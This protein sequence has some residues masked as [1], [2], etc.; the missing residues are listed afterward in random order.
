MKLSFS[1]R[2]SLILGIG[3]LLLVLFFVFAQ[4]YYLT[5]LI[6]D[7]TREQ[8]TLNL[9]QKQ[10][11]IT[12]QKN[13][14]NTNTT[15]NDT[16]ELQQMI[17]VKP[18][19]DQFIL[20]LEKAETLSNSQIK[21]MSFTKDADANGG[22]NQANQQNANGQANTAANQNGI[23]QNTAPQNNANQNNANQN[24][25][26]QGS[27]N[28]ANKPASAAP[29]GL[30]KLTVNLSIESPNYAQI[31]KFIGTLESL[32]RIVVVESISYT[33]GQEITS[34]A[35]STQPLSYNLTVSAFYM[36]T[37]ADLTAQLP[38]IDAP[39]PANKQN[40]LSQFPDTSKS[41]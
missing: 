38:K 23:K 24:Q 22:T 26:N 7:L 12:S 3:I 18:L 17:P 39:A 34:L 31:E 40:P 13:A 10:L 25:T 33:G 11:E 20:D 21:S 41:N 14:V 4:F 16:K 28:Q 35:Q 8:Q 29:S 30:K 2:E 5:P 1:K 19:E 15:M 6:G 36:P 32:K 37:L 9:E 27:A